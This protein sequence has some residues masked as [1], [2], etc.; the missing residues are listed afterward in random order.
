MDVLKA[1]PRRL[2]LVLVLAV[3]AATALVGHLATSPAAEDRTPALSEDGVYSPGSIPE[4]GD[5]AVS[6]AVE[7]LPA[8]LSYDFRDIDSNL[9]RATGF[10]T[11]DFASEFRDTFDKTAR[12]L[13]EDKSAVTN[14]LVRGGA[15]VDTE[16]GEAL[17]LVYI[18]QVLTATAEQEKD[19]A[20]S[21]QSPVKVSQN[22]VRV[23]LTRVGETWK[24]S[25]IEPF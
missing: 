21:T 13:A 15:L 18:D 24:L 1:A 22:R 8:A 2:T 17:V 25:G 14:T 23:S 7:A 12:K 16:E 11:E 6:A 9:D 10:M 20:D 5:E 3:L 19:G 4:D